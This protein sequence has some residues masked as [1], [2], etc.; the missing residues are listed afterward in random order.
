MEQMQCAMCKIYKTSYVCSKC[1]VESPKGSG[2]YVNMPLCQPG[3]QADGD[4]CVRTCFELHKTHGV[5][6][7][8]KKVL[9]P[10]HRNWVASQPAADPH[11]TQQH[12]AGHL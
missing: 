7:Y 4:L 1:T 9:G 10:W 3:V 6:K 8:G 2:I 12:S 5:P 11:G